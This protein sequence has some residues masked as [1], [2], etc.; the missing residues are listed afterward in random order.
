MISQTW[1]INDE[2]KNRILNLHER[3]T[4][5]LYIIKEQET[6]KTFNFG[7][8]FAS[9]QSDLTPEFQSKVS[10]KVK[11]IAEFIKRENVKSANIIIQPGESRVTN[12]PSFSTVGSLATARANSIMNFLNRALPTLLSFTPNITVSEPI[13]GT[14]PY[15]TG[16]DK[17]D[18]RYRAE[19]FVNVIVDTTIKNNPTPE[20]YKRDS[21]VGE[22]IFFN[23]YLIG[24]ISQP[25]VGTQDVKNPGFKDLNYQNLIFTEIKKDSPK[26]IIAKYEIPW[27]WWNEDRE[28]ATTNTISPNDLTKIRSFKKL[29]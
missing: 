1:K 21:D 24:F 8:T 7:D 23:N 20:P 4:K 28:Y 3:A 19:Q 27:K 2:E 26:E 9:G 6:K 5:N 13:I 10:A 25:F 12:Q 17:N 16:D 18:S 11:E 14:T 22:S 29:S 15:V